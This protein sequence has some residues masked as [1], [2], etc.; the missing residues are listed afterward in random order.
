MDA[1]ERFHLG[2]T[3]LAVPRLG[4]G[5]A[6]LGDMRAVIPE[7]QASATIEA[8]H[9][10]GVGYFD[11]SPW[12]GAGKSELRIG[13]VLRTKP[14]ESF[15]LSTKVGRVHRRPADPDGYRHP[16]WVGGLPFEPHFDYSGAGIL[17]SY[18][19]SLARLGLNRVEALLIH[20]LDI[21]HQRTEHAVDA[22]LRQLDDSGFQALASLKERGEILAIG[23]GINL[24]GMIPRFLERYPIDFFLVAMPYTLLDQAGLDELDLCRARDVSVVIG[25]PFASGV[26]ARGPAPGATYGYRR[27]K[28]ET[29]EKAARIQEVCRRFDIPLAAAALQ[30][31]L[32]HPA[33]ASIIPG[34][35]SPEEALQNLAWM[36]MD[37]PAALWAALKAEGLIRQ[38][39]PTPAEGG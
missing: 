7:A 3:A 14:R 28:P 29:L 25:A 11:T 6:S 21:G 10:A 37:L 18:E 20:D 15:V 32:G 19:M 1:F 26:L 8:A 5:G 24:V 34:P 39:A 17:K 22:G 38:D 9:G 12:Y 31:P 36:Q 4:F 33:V 35:I 2:R 27:A 13:H 16:A 23:A 30:F